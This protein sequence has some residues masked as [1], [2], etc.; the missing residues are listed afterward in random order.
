MSE[1]IITRIAPSPTGN[2]HIGTARASLFNFLFARKHKGKFIIRIED[3]DKERSKKEYEENILESLSWLSLTGDELY[4]Q[5]EREEIYKTYLK[6]MIDG[7]F[8]Y[9]SKEEPKIEGGRTEVIRFKNPNKTVTFQDIIRGEVTFDTTELHDFV[10]AKSLEEP[11]YHLAVVVDDHEMGVTHVIRGE[12]HI[13]N[14]PRQILIQEAIGAGRPI[15][16]HIPLILA[17]DRSKL[18]KRHGATSVVEYKE[19]GY[20]PEAVLNY[21]ALLGWNPGTDQEVF[22]LDELI[23]AFDISKVQKGG[24]IFDEEKLKWINKEHLK[25][26]SPEN[27]EKEIVSRVTDS[28]I[29][30]TKNWKLPENGDVS[31]FVSTAFERVSYWKDLSDLL[32]NGDLNYFFE[33]PQYSKDKL[34]WK[35]EK[36]STTTVRHI[37]KV[38]EIMETIATTDWITE[39]IKE[40]LWDYA[41]KEGRGSVLW[42]VRFALSG[43][44]KSPDPFTLAQILGKKETLDRLEDARKKLL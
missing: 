19:R 37:E 6:K 5:S 42:P 15:Y 43:K 28:E 41:D 9:V 7:G 36:E 32:E 8:A 27:L 12:D 21:L 20:L 11:L 25:K 38:V 24:A 2:L 16:G 40:L 23:E 30:K 26:F 31:K 29:F 13:S 18:S 22:T 35:D 14:T 4:R 1:K 44:D 17:P 3:T 34:F 33:K 10:I 39:K